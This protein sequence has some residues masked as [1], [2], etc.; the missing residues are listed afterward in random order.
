MNDSELSQLMKDM[1]TASNDVRDQHISVAVTNFNSTSSRKGSRVALW[2]VAAAALLVVGAGIG[3]TL[4]N[5]TD[6]EPNIYADADIENLGGMSSAAIDSSTGDT[7]A[8]VKGAPPAIGPC[9]AQYTEEKFIAVV[10]IG[11][12]RVAVYATP[13]STEPLVRLVDPDSCDELAITRR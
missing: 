10:R 2:S 5:A 6:S 12:D 8:A 9:D 3:V 1:P 11:T 13:S 7:V 4:Q